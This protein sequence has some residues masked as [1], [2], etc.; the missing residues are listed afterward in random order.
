MQKAQNKSIRLI[1][2]KS[3]LDYIYKKYNILNIH[4]LISLE[5]TKFGYKAIN[6]LLPQKVKDLLHLDQFDGNLVKN[7]PYQTRNKKIPN[8]HRA[9][10][11]AYNNSF[12]CKGLI[13]LGN[14]NHDLKN[15]NS[16]KNFICAF[17][18]SFNNP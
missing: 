14:L 4:E 9:K 2:T 7:N 5:N 1:D 6:N 3:K 8:Y 13:R 10:T 18:K 17:K 16:L 15:K 12:L 11:Q